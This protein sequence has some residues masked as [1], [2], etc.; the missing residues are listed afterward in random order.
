MS[1]KGN[2]AASLLLFVLFVAYGLGA[3]TI[4]MFP[5]QELEP[6]KPRT[7]PVLLALTGV[8]LCIIR[9]VQLL[10]AP[11]AEWQPGVDG[12]RWK[13]AGLL[14]VAMLAYGFAINPLG[15]VLATR[16]FL[17][18]GFFVLGER[19]VPLLLGLSTTFSLIFYLL[20]TRA[21]GLYLAPGPWWGA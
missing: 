4:P 2:I 11:E 1:V 3:M 7:M 15:F 9:I 19:R 17:A 10:R 8:A 16:L 21:L 14:C 13:Q 6:F 5:G 12:F 18:T 20:M